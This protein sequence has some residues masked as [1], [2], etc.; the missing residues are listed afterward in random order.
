MRNHSHAGMQVKA[1]GGVRTLDKLPGVRALGVSRVGASHTVEMLDEC[2]KRLGGV[3]NSLTLRRNLWVGLSRGAGPW[4][5][6]AG[7]AG[8]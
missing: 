8:Q 6:F 5:V 4:C 2:C 3:V 1:A 7:M